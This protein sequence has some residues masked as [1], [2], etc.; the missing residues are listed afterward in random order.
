MVAAAE[1]IFEAVREQMGPS[2]KDTAS[3]L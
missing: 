2:A 3:G 1:V